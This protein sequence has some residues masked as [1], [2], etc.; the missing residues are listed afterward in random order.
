[1]K[2]DFVKVIENNNSPNS[3]NASIIYYKQKDTWLLLWRKK[4]LK[5]YT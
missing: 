2:K 5:K 1:M 4:T 3:K